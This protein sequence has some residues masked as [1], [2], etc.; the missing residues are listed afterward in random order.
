MKD[1]TFI[2]LNNGYNFSN[3]VTPNPAQHTT[4]T[5]TTNTRLS[6]ARPNHQSIPF[7][8]HPLPDLEESRLKEV[9]RKYQIEMKRWSKL[10]RN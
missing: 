2:N 4:W 8:I 6:I 1:S 3:E 9:E 7:K 5:T 10:N